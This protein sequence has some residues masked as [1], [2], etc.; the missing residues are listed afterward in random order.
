MV[1]YCYNSRVAIRRGNPVMKELDGTTVNAT[2]REGELALGLE[3]DVEQGQLRVSN[4]H[5]GP[6]S[7]RTR[8]HAHSNT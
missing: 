4:G 5:E 3:G 7:S 6:V 8:K 1:W 2:S